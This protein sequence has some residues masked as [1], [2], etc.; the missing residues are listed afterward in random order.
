MVTCKECGY[1]NNGRK[2]CKRCGAVLDLSEEKKITSF[3]DIPDISMYEVNRELKK[4]IRYFTPMQAQY[5]EYDYCNQ[6]LDF[7]DKKGY[8]PKGVLIFG[9]CTMGTMIWLAVL[10]I[11]YAFKLYNGLLLWYAM[12][13]AN[14]LYAA[15][16]YFRSLKDNR[17][18]IKKYLG[19]EVELARQLTNHYNNYGPC[20]IE[21]KY[22]D[23]KILDRLAYIIQ[24]RKCDT[25]EQA[26]DILYSDSGRSKE[27]HEKY[28]ALVA[29]RQ[30]EF[31]EKDALVFGSCNYF[32]A[33]HKVGEKLTSIV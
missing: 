32:G 10:T 19:R 3:D 16:A 27:E 30:A 9:I 21:A 4:M 13:F 31:G 5:S 33:Y 8:I 26:F 28:L 25:L 17:T 2:I 24:N 22:T 20:L 7:L 1:E 15:V 14:G 29:S 23:P 18:K 6:K 12:I 11:I